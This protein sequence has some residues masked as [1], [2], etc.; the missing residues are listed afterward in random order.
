MRIHKTTW[1][2]VIPAALFAVLLH[3]TSV[4]AA[5]P[6]SLTVQ[7]PRQVNLG[8]EVKVTAVLTDNQ[9]R[10]IPGASILLLTPGD[11][12]SV[13]S[14]IELDRATTDTQGTASLRYQ[15]RTENSVTLTASFPGNNRYSPSQASTDITVDGAGQLYQETAVVLPGIRVWWLLVGVLG[16]A[17]SIYFSVMVLVTLIARADMPAP[18]R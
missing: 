12:L 16:V 14:T 15:A 11:F 3:T 1:V 9:R 8:D 18:E 6:V 7:A 5:E 13:E 4:L 17:W 2:W 10:P